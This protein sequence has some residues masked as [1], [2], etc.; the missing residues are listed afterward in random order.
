MNLVNAQQARRVLDRLVG[1]ELSPVLWKKVKPSLSAGRV[2]SVA[3]RL[4]VEREK[5][6]IDFKPVQYFR[7]TGNFNNVE[8]VAFNAELNKRLPDA[9]QARRLLEICNSSAFTVRNI[10]KKPSKRSPAAPFTTST[11]QQEASRKLGMSVGQTMSVAQR[12]YEAGLISYMRT[13]SQSLSAEAIGAISSEVRNNFGEQYLKTRVYKTKAK[14]AQEAH[15]AIRPTYIQNHTIE[16][17]P[18][19]KRLYELIWKRTVASQMEDA[20]IDR[21]V[22]EIGIDADPEYHFNATGEVITFDGF[23]RLYSE[24]TDDE[25]A[26]EA[27]GILPRM[28]VG[29][30]VSANGIVATQRFTSPAARYSEASLVKRLEDLGIGRPST[31]A[32]TISTIISR[33]YVLRESREGQKREYLQIKLEKNKVVEKTAVETYGTEKNKLFPTDIGI[34]VTDYLETQ[35][36]S[37]LDY[38][39]TASVEKEFDE[40]AEGD[41]NWTTMLGKFYG[42]FHPTVEAAIEHSDHASGTRL[43]GTDPLSG[44]PVYAKIGRFGPYIQLGENEDIA[45]K[46]PQYANLASGQLSATITLDEAMILFQLP[47]NVGQYEEKDVVIGVGRFGPY[48]RHD[49]KFVSLKK[50]DNPYTITLERA[51]E[52]IEAKRKQESER[53]IKTFS[54]DAELQILNGRWGPYISY[55][56]ANYKLPKS[57]SVPSELTYDDCMKLVSEQGTKDSKATKPKAKG[58]RKAK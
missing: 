49:N 41:I 16:G 46:K 26:E 23:L 14:G 45:G 11:L 13:D 33:G 4:I 22:V 58:R 35:F 28:S 38:N 31:Y 30:K 53:V 44:Q 8:S 17:S 48:V 2:Q 34:L 6:I 5:E 27:E 47:R 43:I 40:I 7:V 20:R 18:Q 37:I 36:P 9:E 15:E 50:E 12:L 3:V 42:Q 24:S 19:E 10:E 54:Q 39:F 21:T 25:Q 1:F 56:K 52:L 55:K 29:E 57:V 32:P 51:V